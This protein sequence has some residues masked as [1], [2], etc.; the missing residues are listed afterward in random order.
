MISMRIN[1]E[2]KN[3]CAVSGSH[4]NVLQSQECDEMLWEVLPFQLDTRRCCFIKGVQMGTHRFNNY[5]ISSKIKENGRG[6]GA[7]HLTLEKQILPML[8][9]PIQNINSEAVGIVYK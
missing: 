9:F 1:C 3:I 6:E 8:L 7:N 5:W 4:P 2:I